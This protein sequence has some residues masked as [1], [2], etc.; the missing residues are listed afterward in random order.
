MH[1]YYIFFPYSPN[2]GIFL[3]Y[4]SWTTP[5]KEQFTPRQTEMIENIKIPLNPLIS[6]FPSRW[7]NI[8][9]I[10]DLFSLSSTSKEC[11]KVIF[12]ALEI[13][14]LNPNEPSLALWCDI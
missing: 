2:N 9:D 12:K 1:E 13:F 3:F 7:I 10:R 6:N 8:E 5:Y 4:E 14:F 11:F